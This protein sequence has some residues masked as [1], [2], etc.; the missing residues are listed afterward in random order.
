MQTVKANGPSNNLTES[1]QQAALLT[2]YRNRVK[3]HGKWFSG[4]YIQLDGYEFERCRFDQCSL[5][6]A[7]GDFIMKDCFISDNNKLLVCDGA[8]RVVTFLLYRLSQGNTMFKSVFSSVP[9]L[10]PKFN[11]DGTIS[12]GA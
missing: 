10:S 4:N 3:V 1:E 11:S 8:Q 2:A 9:S 7:N 6:S 5:I 12:I